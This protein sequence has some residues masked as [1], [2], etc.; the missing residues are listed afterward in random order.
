MLGA[1]AK[2]MKDGA[3]GLAIKAFLNDRLK[4]FGDVVECTVDTGKSRIS[5]KA[6]LKGEKE[7]ITASVEK[8]ELVR[9]GQDVYAVLKAFSSSKPWLTLLLQK[10]FTGKRYKLPGAVGSLL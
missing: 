8:Y 7:P 4:D 10:L 5:L 9:E 1:L 6:L 2:G 3:L